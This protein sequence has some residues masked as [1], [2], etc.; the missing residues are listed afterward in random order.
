MKSTDSYQLYTDEELVDL[1]AGDD[2][3]AFTEIYNRY[4]GVLFLHA[5]KRLQDREAAKD[6]I[7]DIFESL[8]SKRMVMTIE[9]QLANYLYTVVR[10]KIINL[11][12]REK[13][14]SV[15]EATWKELMVEEQPLPDCL[16]REKELKQLIEAEAS[17]LPKK[18]RDIFYMSRELHLTHS[19]IAEQLNLSPATVKKQVNNALKVLRVKFQTLVI[20]LL[21]LV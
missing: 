18:M 9:S 17:R 3:P 12:V 11:E 7:Q 2:Y 10:Y 1:M 21:L 13:R 16:V 20:L 19:E 14:L 4:A 15:L 8:W 5:Q 6:L